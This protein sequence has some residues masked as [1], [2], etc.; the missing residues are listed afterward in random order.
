MAFEVL[1]I[2][3]S[4]FKNNKG[5]CIVVVSRQIAPSVTPSKQTS[6]TREKFVQN[7]T[8]SILNSSFSGNIGGAIFVN[9]ANI[10][11]I[12]KGS[13][14]TR[15]TADA[16]G[17]IVSFNSIITSSHFELNTAPGSG[18]GA[19]A[20]KF[21]TMISNTTFIQNRAG[22]GGAIIGQ[23]FARFSC[24]SCLFQNNTAE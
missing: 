1:F 4:V 14:F 16:G 11:L 9:N 17:A 6:T 13:T 10:Q 18:G 23:Q 5:G 24:N 8:V 15:N 21:Q 2:N 7:K 3:L 20:F 19:I 12:I 22:Y